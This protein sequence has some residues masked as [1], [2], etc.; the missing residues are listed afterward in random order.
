MEIHIPIKDALLKYGHDKFNLEILEY[1]EKEDLIERE[2]YYLDKLTPE[3]NVLKQAYSLLGFKHS[4]ET[5]EKLRLKTLSEEQKEFISQ[6]H[7][8]KKVEEETRLKLSESLKEYHK[9]NPLTS[10]ALENITRK[11]TE[12]EGVKVTLKNLETDEE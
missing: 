3:Y 7:T 8:G 12:R 5:I 6:L 2:Q 1:C 11:T 10:E 9:N 4:D